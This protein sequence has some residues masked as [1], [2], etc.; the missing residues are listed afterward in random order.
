MQ[1]AV[2]FM[3]VTDQLLVRFVMG[4]TVVVNDKYPHPIVI[5]ARR[6]QAG[7]LYT[8]PLPTC[9]STCAI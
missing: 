8:P 4:K 5:G 2:D 9:L 3:H 1:V 6:P 7:L